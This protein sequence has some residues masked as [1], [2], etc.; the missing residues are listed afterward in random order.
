MW[1]FG[2]RW[3]L[4]VAGVSPKY[5]NACT[6]TRPGSLHT[7]SHVVCSEP[8]RRFLAVSPFGMRASSRSLYLQLSNTTMNVK[9]E[10]SPPLLQPT[11]LTQSPNIS[12]SRRPD[13]IFL[14]S[15]PWRERTSLEDT[16][17]PPR[18]L[19]LRP[20]RCTPQIR[21][22]QPPRGDRSGFALDFTSSQQWEFAD[23]QRK[24]H[25]AWNAA[26]SESH[27]VFSRLE[28]L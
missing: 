10:R 19:L 4:H 26:S 1:C 27:S 20:Y 24:V 21:R 9:T 15:L 2:V 5:R 14:R 8:A 11:D 22:R 7:F 16:P 18:R 3:Y 6:V 12:A 23:K 25:L 17:P 28:F 13:W